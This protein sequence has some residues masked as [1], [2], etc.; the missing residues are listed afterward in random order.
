MENPSDLIE[1][2]WLVAFAFAGHGL[3]HGFRLPCPFQ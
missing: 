3:K 2:F 1:K